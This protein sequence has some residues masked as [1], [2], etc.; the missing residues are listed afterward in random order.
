MIRKNKKENSTVAA[1]MIT[2]RRGRVR[3][4]HND[5]LAAR[6]L[7]PDG[8]AWNIRQAAKWSGIGEATLRAMAKAGAIPVVR[9]GRRILIPR[10]GFQRWF[11]AG[12][13]VA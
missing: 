13:A 11:N 3:R 1:A 6:G 5:K 9:A 12:E 10:E 2:D 8:G 4:A 7:G